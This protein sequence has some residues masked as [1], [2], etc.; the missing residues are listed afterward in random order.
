VL[1]PLL[2]IGG[3]AI[4]SWNGLSFTAAAEIA[5]RARA[6]TAMSLQNML[7][8]ILG[9]AASPL[10]GLLVEATSYRAAYLSIAAAPILGWFV[11]GPL[12]T[13]EEERAEARRRR[14]ATYAVQP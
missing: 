8:S 5:G 13:D 11:L 4:S 3:A 10:F 6:G 7:V 9:A 2:V 14:L 12:E 1:L